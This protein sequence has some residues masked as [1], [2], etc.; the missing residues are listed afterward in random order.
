M[1]CSPLARKQ[2][3]PLDG[4]LRDRTGIALL[5]PVPGRVV[6]DLGA[7][8]GGQGLRHVLWRGLAAEHRLE[9]A[10]VAGHGVQK[11]RHLGGVG[12]NLRTPG[13]GD[14]ALQCGGPAIPV[15]GGLVAHVVQAGCVARIQVAVVLAQERLRIGPAQRPV[16]AALAGHLAAARQAPVD[17]QLLA[18]R[19]LGRGVRVVGRVLHRLQR[20]WAPRRG[21]PGVAG[22][23]GGQQGRQRRQ[24]QNR[25]CSHI[26]RSY[27]WSVKAA[28][29]GPHRPS[30]NRR[31]SRAW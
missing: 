22:A 25:R 9:L 24:D 4:S 17:E 15:P 12:T 11:R 18:Q 23:S 27:P 14:L 30:V 29:V 2:R 5:V 26:H 1:R 31:P 8:M 13:G 19:R 3:L 16:V 20:R 6:A 28:L 7:E 21:L 10:A